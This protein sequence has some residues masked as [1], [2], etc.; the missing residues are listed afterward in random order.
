MWSSLPNQPNT[1]LSLGATYGF[2][3]PQLMYRRK[4]TPY[5]RME[6]CARHLNLKYK[7]F[8]SKEKSSGPERCARGGL[9]WM[10]KAAVT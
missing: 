9:G 8:Q 1:S 10:V 2:C 3:D 5:F 6:E 7:N 4:Y